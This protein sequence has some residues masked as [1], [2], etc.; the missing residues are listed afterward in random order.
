MELKPNNN[1]VKSATREKI[2]ASAIASFRIE[3]IIISKEQAI[4]ALKKIEASLEK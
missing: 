1:T 2:A 4:A 3:G